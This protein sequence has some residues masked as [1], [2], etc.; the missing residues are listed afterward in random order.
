MQ[1]AEALHQ[2]AAECSKMHKDAE[3]IPVHQSAAD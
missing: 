2:N 1:Q 3:C